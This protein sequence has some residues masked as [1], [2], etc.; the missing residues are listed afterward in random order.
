MRLAIPIALL[1]GATSTIA[2]AE[3]GKDVNYAPFAPSAKPAEKLTVETSDSDHEAMRLKPGLGYFGRVDAPLARDVDA[4]PVHLVGMRLWFRRRVGLDLAVGANVD[5]GEGP[6][7]FAFGARASLPIALVVEPHLTLF[8]AP[9]IAFAMANETIPGARASNPIT[10]LPYTPPDT[11]RRGLGFAGGARLGGELQLGAIGLSRVGLIASVGLD[12][13]Y[14]RGN[15]RSA[16]APTT[17]DPEPRAADDS[18]NRLAVDTSFV[19]NLGVV[20]YF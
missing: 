7:M 18:S 20:F 19:S 2:S 11:Q 16:P 14:V 10:G 13:H 9:T 5:T 17:R 4:V 15:E 1:V 12:L 8:A 3:T 6:R